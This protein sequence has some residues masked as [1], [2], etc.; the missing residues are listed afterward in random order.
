MSHDV[1]LGAI[2]NAMPETS[3]VLQN[4]TLKFLKNL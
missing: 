1:V 2:K 4:D 3:S